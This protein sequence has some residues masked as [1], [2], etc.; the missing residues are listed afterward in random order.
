MELGAKGMGFGNWPL[1]WSQVTSSHLYSICPDAKESS[2]AVPEEAG[3]KLNLRG[4]F[5]G[6]GKNVE[7]PSGLLRTIVTHLSGK[8][9]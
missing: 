5:L 9:L 8:G 3:E 1:T 6:R 4:V 7:N 2:G